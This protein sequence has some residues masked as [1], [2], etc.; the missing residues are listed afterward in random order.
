MKAGQNK[1][2]VRV[3]FVMSEQDA[4]LVK[5]RM[6]ELGITNLSA[7]LRKMAVDGYIIHLDMGDIQEMVRLLRI[8]SNNLN[9]Y[10]KR[11][12]ETGSVYA[13]DVEDLRTRLD[14][15]WDGMDKLLRGFANIS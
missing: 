3:E 4:E 11:A 12:N 10:A 6:A 5:G 7:Y 15:L 8:C 14:G 1:K 9:Q 2:T 13:A